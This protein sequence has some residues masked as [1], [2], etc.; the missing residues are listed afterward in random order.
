V[1]N[2]TDI[3]DKMIKRADEE[4]TG[5]KE[6][7]DKYIEEYFI[8][9]AGL[10]IK[11]ASVHPKATENIEAIID[12]IKELE[13]KGYAYY[14]NG[15]VYFD[16]R[17]FKEYGKLSH[18]SLEDLE[19]GARVEVDE[20]SVILWTLLCGRLKSLVNLH[21]TALGAKEGRGGI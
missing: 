13:N 16:T 15:D 14:V 18:Q 5:I 8:D 19:H 1:Q 21:G 4:G 3:D 10:G 12:M 9:A 11:E 6:L 17:K 2:F 7:A 20:E